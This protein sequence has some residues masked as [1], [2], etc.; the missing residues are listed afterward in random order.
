MNASA[1][2][3]RWAPNDRA[4]RSHSTSPLPPLCTP[5][6]Q[7]TCGRI[8]RHQEVFKKIAQGNLYRIMY[9]MGALD[10]DIGRYIGRCIGR[11]IGR[12]PVD[13]RPMLDRCST[14]ARP[15]L[16]QCS[17]DARPM[18]GYIGRYSV[19]TRPML[20]RCSTDARPMLDRCSTDARVK[21]RL[22]I[23]RCIDRYSVDM[24]PFDRRYI[25]R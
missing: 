19:D 3:D 6:T 11:Y 1:K 18:L 22:S 14:D 16:D 20:D 2:R 10:R 21:C 7:A 8:F 24:F 25:G 13:T 23:D 15:I 9:L 17:T 12:Y 5:A 4:S